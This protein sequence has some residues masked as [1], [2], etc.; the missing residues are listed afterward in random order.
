MNSIK[1]KQK[2]FKCKQSINMRTKV[3]VFFLVIMSCIITIQAQTPAQKIE[4]IVD[5]YGE[6]GLFN[7][8]ILVAQKGKKK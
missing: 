3:I 5:H 7:G 4:K 1:M 2:Y 8:S 6:E